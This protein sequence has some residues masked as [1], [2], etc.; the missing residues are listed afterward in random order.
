MLYKSIKEE[1]NANNTHTQN[2]NPHGNQKTVTNNI[3][4]YKN[5]QKNYCKFENL[6]QFS[7]QCG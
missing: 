6:Q 3:S 4:V 7:D 1:E 5:K 2:K